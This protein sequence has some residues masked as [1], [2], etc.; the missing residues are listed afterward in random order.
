[1]SRAEVGNLEVEIEIVRLWSE[2]EEL[3]LM[4]HLMSP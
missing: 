2:C 3:T 1:M 4:T